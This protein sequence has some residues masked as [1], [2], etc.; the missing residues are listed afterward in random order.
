MINRKF[1]I[2]AREAFIMTIGFL[3]RKLQELLNSHATLLWL[4]GSKTDQ[5]ES[6]KVIEKKLI[7]SLRN[8]A[9]RMITFERFATTKVGLQFWNKGRAGVLYR[10]D[11]ISKSP[12]FGEYG[13]CLTKQND[14]DFTPPPY[15]VA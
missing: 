14:Q 4:E 10:W 11:A 7:L 5:V 6:A 15:F 13:D 3:E 2:Y 1:I 8:G 9:T 12:G